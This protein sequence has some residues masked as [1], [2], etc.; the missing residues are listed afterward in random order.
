MSEKNLL[1]ALS[2]CSRIEQQA[3]IICDTD[4]LKPS[5]LVTMAAYI[6][7]HKIPSKNFQIGQN[8]R[9]Y[10]DTIGFCSLWGNTYDIH[11]PNLG[12]NYSMLTLLDNEHAT[13]TAN[14]QIIS[15]ISHFTNNDTS[16]GIGSLKEVVGELHDNIW[17]HGRSTGFSMAQKYSNGKIEF[18]LADCGMGF[19]N[20]LRRIGMEIASHKEAIEWC[21]KK[22]N[23]SKKI[24]SERHDNWG[25]TTTSRYYW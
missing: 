17:S 12:R 16:D 3:I 24:E 18:A 15:C 7:K 14:T 19:L 5:Y 9:G 6:T 10:L 11:R 2:D 8:H 4:F 25:T 21:I 20:E 22:G 1:S 13:D 23:S